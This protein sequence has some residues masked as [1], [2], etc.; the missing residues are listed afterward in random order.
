[1]AESSPPPLDEPMPRHGPLLYRPLCDDTSLNFTL[2]TLL[3][4]P[5]PHD[6]RRTGTDR[7]QLRTA[8]REEI[9]APAATM[10]GSRAE[11]GVTVHRAGIK[12]PT[13]HADASAEKESETT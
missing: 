12:A 2:L 6:H 5:Q 13:H 3:T 4:S 9:A 8:L 11:A 10:V 1:M 7:T